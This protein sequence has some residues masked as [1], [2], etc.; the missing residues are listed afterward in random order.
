VLC[1]DGSGVQFIR[2]LTR[3]GAIFDLVE[4]SGPS[5]EL[6]GACFS[7]DGEL[8]FFNIQGSTRST[9]RELGFTF[10]M[11]GPWETGAL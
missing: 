6:A 4:T 2:G 11:W 8:F 3:E 5:P 9:G 10:A 1:E 7:P